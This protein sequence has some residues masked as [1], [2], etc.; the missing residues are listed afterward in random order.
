MNKKQ[1]GKRADKDHDRALDDHEDTTED[2]DSLI[3]IRTQVGQIKEIIDKMDKTLM[4]NG[5]EGL[6]AMVTKNTSDIRTIKVS[7][8]KQ[9]R[10][11]L[12][13]VGLIMSAGML[14]MMIL[15][16]LKL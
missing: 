13:L 10:N 2:H 12:I 14:I 1:D 7:H 4:G 16:Y 8:E 5:K 9:Q 6:C 3:V 11:T 15:N